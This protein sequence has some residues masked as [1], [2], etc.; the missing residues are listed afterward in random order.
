MIECYDS[1][2]PNFSTIVYSK[3][4]IAKLT[5]RFHGPQNPSAKWEAIRAGSQNSL[6]SSH[7]TLQI[8]PEPINRVSQV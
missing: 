2:S 8:Q 3:I 4:L 6:G 1:F 5:T 7:I